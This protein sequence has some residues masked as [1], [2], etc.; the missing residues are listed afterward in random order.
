D[1]SLTPAI[2]LA[3]LTQSDHRGRG[4]SPGGMSCSNRLFVLPGLPPR[5]RWSLCVRSARC[6]AGVEAAVLG[7]RRVDL[8]MTFLLA[9]RVALHRAASRDVSPPTASR[10]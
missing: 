10:C 5:P 8:N 1:R 9:G 2:H 3:D 4:G 6:M 7:E